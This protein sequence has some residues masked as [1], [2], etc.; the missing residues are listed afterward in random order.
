MNTNQQHASI[1]RIRD[2]LQTYL[3]ERKNEKAAPVAIVEKGPIESVK[4]EYRGNQY[5]LDQFLYRQSQIVY[6]AS[7]SKNKKQEVI[8]TH[9]EFDSDSFERTRYLKKWGRLDEFAKQ[10]VVKKYIQELVDSGKING[11]QQKMLTTQALDLI[12]EKQLKKVDYDE[13]AGKVYEIAQLG[14]ASLR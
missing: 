5:E 7:L 4:K 9:K 3:Q 6:Y 12:R 2:H 11:D 14:L 10:V 8:R 1:S 13:H